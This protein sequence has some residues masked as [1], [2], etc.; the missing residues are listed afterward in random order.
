L[1]AVLVVLTLPEVSFARTEPIVIVDR[2]DYNVVEGSPAYYSVKVLNTEEKDEI[3]YQWFY[4]IN[5]LAGESLFPGDYYLPNTWFTRWYYAQ[6]FE[7]T[8]VDVNESMLNKATMDHFQWMSNE[9]DAER[10][11]ENQ[12]AFVCRVTINGKNYDS[13]VFTTT[14]LSKDYL[15][16]IQVTIDEGDI[17]TGKDMYAVD[18]SNE[19]E[20]V[21][22]EDVRWQK[23]SVGQWTDLDSS[24]NFENGSYRAVISL[25]VED[26]WTFRR[27]PS[28]FVNG[29]EVN[30]F[31]RHGTG[32]REIFLYK[33]YYVNENFDTSASFTPYSSQYTNGNIFR[34]IK[35]AEFTYLEDGSD[36][37][38]TL[39]KG[40]LVVLLESGKKDDSYYVHSDTAGKNGKIPADCLEFYGYGDGKKEYP[41]TQNY[42]VRHPVD[43]LGDSVYGDKIGTLPVGVV[44][45]ATE[46]FGYFIKFNYNGRDGWLFAWWL[47]PTEQQATDISYM[48][49]T[50]GFYR[51]TA[52]SVNVRADMS[53]S[54]ERVG[55]LKQGTVIFVEGFGGEYAGFYYQGRMRFVKKEVLE[56]LS[57]DELGTIN[58][59]VT[60][61]PVN[62][63]VK[64]GGKVVFT[65]V[66]TAT[67][68]ADKLY[69]YDEVDHYAAFTY[70]WS[71]DIPIQAI[72]EN[73]WGKIE[74][75]EDY[76]TLTI[77]DC[78]DELDGMRVLCQMKGFSVVNTDYATLTVECT[79]ENNHKE[80]VDEVAIQGTSANVKIKRILDIKAG[81]ES[82]G[83]VDLYVEGIDEKGKVHLK[84]VPKE[85]V[86]LNAN[87]KKSDIKISIPNYSLG[88][89][90]IDSNGFLDV[91]LN[92]EVKEEETA[93][94]KGAFALES[95]LVS[96]APKKSLSYSFNLMNKT[97]GKPTYKLVSGEL[98]KGVSLGSN[99][100]VGTPETGSEG[101]YEIKISASVEAQYETKVTE[102]P[103]YKMVDEYETMRVENEVPLQH[104]Y[105]VS[106]VVDPDHYSKIVY[107][108]DPDH[109]NTWV[110]VFP[111]TQKATVHYV[112]EYLDEAYECNLVGVEGTA[113]T[114]FTGWIIFSTL[115]YHTEE[116]K[117]G[118]HQE[119]DHYEK[120]TEKV[121]VTPASKTE[122][123]LTLVVES[124]HV[125][126]FKEKSNTPST[127]TKTGSIVYECKC[128]ESLTKQLPLTEHSFSAW[129]VEI[130]GEDSYVRFRI[131]ENC[132]LREEHAIEK[133]NHK[134]VDMD[135]FCDFCHKD[136]SSIAIANATGISVSE[137]E[138]GKDLTDWSEDMGFVKDGEPKPA[139]PAPVTEEA[140]EP[141]AEPSTEPTSEI[142]VEPTPETDSKSD[143]DSKS[144]GMSAGAIILIIIVILLILLLAIYI[145]VRAM[146][147]KKK[148]DKNKKSQG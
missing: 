70:N 109:P 90:K 126:D 17:A 15:N 112:G 30:L 68:Y 19:T 14:V 87:L 51:V 48:F 95:E 94:N 60:K 119:I 52:G 46:M 147:D 35:D 9:E 114:G 2:Y 41:T 6:E 23:L 97:K 62:T 59:V 21:T 121:E 134:D 81:G 136:M 131:C 91:T 7:R 38:I 8:V 28:A 140:T 33:T 65:A 135:L 11:V 50:Q 132:G 141:S 47:A 63:E 43:V 79:D 20:H 54:A 116:V 108:I 111:M 72:E 36:K 1:A 76:S 86:A 117:T 57:E 10:S 88:D 129:D 98:P 103:V 113:D 34:L 138:A 85:G 107:N 110:E 18:I 145:L 45:T 32:D 64:E 56:K 84:V 106:F 93:T 82:A 40:D 146:T 143:S 122:A 118:A 115:G 128:G 42:V 49:D 29:E 127:C 27:N 83:D 74:F 16:D 101:I 22:L 124:E 99:G 75:S 77:S 37:T 137:I 55:G 44:V 130:T 105:Q 12:W 66:A 67:G 100:L 123:T 53:D 26:G 4:T 120:K 148:K 24:G 69:R 78:T 13:P 61:N 139:D 104:E 31:S 25:R 144:K 71:L 5:C 92:P 39:K 96:M 80:Q 3:T 102:V 125:H 73:G 58:P 89:F 142:S 133:H